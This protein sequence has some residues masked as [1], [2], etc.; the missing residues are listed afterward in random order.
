[1]LKEETLSALLIRNARKY[2][3]KTA[4]REKEFGIWREISWSEYLQNVKHFSLGLMKLGLGKEEKVAIMGDN[5]P[6][7]L[8][9][10]LGCQAAL[11]IPVGIFE[12]SLIAEVEYIIN[13]SDAEI[14]VAIDQ[15]QVDKVLSLLPRLPNVRFI[16]YSEPKGLHSYDDSHLM[17]FEDVVS[18]GRELETEDPDLFESN[19]S[20]LD[21]DDT[22]LLAYTSGTTGTPKG[23]LISYNNII[24][25]TRNFNEILP[26]HPDDRFLSFLPLPW[27]GEQY[28]AVFAALYSAFTVNFPEEPETALADLYEIGPTLIFGPP[29]F[30]EKFCSN[31]Q[32]AHLDATYLKGLVYRICL[33]IGYGWAKF[34]FDK[35][36][37]P[38]YWKALYGISFLLIFRPLRDRL[39]LSKVKSALTGGG[40]MAPEI[41]N[42]FHALGVN[43]KQMLGITELSALLAMHRD[44][45]ICPD[46]I[47][48]AAPEV[49]FRFTE[50]GEI[51]VS[52]PGLFQGYYKDR[53]KTEEVV[54]DGKWFRTGDAGY[55]T[56]NKHLVLIDRVA[57]LMRMSDGTK[58][59]P[60]FI[61]TK[62]NFSPYITHAVILGDKRPFIT[63]IICIDFSNVG[64]W[65]EDKGLGYTT[66][67]DLASKSQVYDL[68]EWEVYEV[69]KRIPAKM[70]I[71]AFIL[72]Y[73]ELDADDGELTRTKKLRRNIVVDKYSNEIEALY[74]SEDSVQIDSVI[75]YQDGT[76]KGICAQLRIRRMK[77]M[78]EYEQ[79]EKRGLKKLISELFS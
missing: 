26:K 51:L 18:L 12:D 73:K 41:F 24:R 71:Q 45:D 79:L 54:P 34:K 39:G 68:I 25:T 6:E 13:H 70:R 72:L 20:R 53:A 3:E 16:I 44:D 48:P 69:N 15:E 36:I 4:L 46:T 17:Y 31:V 14:V 67:T 77:K 30:W 23:V 9:A 22:A 19:V 1:M 64:K 40:Q 42:F 33:P 21:G 11:G 57:H 60:L 49:E 56:D 59:S 65:A 63:A 75:Q 50:E 62:L 7:W 61:E 5:R 74:G 2:G 76:T 52:S 27:V 28:M 32:V 66:Y 38:W 43:L 78:E 10:E 35:K 37:P 55:M 29:K 8:Y 47:G 58:F